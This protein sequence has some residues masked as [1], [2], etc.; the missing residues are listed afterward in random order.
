MYNLYT[1]ALKEEKHAHYLTSDI[2]IF[3]KKNNFF[4]LFDKKAK[5]GL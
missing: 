1:A 3:L 2:A 5:V 4:G